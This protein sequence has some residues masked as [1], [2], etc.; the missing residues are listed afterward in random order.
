[1][2]HDGK[3][4]YIV[5]LCTQVEVWEEIPAKRTYY[6]VWSYSSICYT[7]VCIIF[8]SCVCHA[9]SQTLLLLLLLLQNNCIDSWNT[10]IHICYVERHKNQDDAVPRVLDQDWEDVSSILHLIID[11]LS[12]FHPSFSLSLICH[13]NGCCK[14]KMEKKK[15][16]Y[17]AECLKL[18]ERI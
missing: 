15:T 3:F 16:M 18:R 11:L 7:F 8:D 4:L 12:N 6:P 17:S 13:S 2:H 10:V 1:M 14:S 9:G 5:V